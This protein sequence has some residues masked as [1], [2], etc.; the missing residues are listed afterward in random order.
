MHEWVKTMLG[1]TP[2]TVVQTIAWAI[3]CVSSYPK[4]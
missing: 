1:R 4:I 3:L 2:A